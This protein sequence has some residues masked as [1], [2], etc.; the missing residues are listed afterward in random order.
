MKRV[1]LP[2]MIAGSFFTAGGGDCTTPASPMGPQMVITDSSTLGAATHDFCTQALIVIG[3]NI[4]ATS[5][6]TVTCT[7]DTPYSVAINQ[8]LNDGG[9]GINARK[10]KIGSTSD[11]VNYQLY[12]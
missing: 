10:M 1:L 9:F 12:S 7:N 11:T 5:T 4:D 6:M 3:S 8:G 2:S